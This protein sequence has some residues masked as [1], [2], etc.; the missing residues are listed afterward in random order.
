MSHLLEIRNL[1][2]E[3]PAD[4]DRQYAVEGLSLQ[5][6]RGETVCVV[7]E[8]GSGKSVTAHAVMQLLPEHALNISSGEI[9]LDGVNLLELDEDTMRQY[10]GSRLAMVFQEPMTALNPVMTVGDQVEETLLAH[11][12]LDGKVSRAKVIQLLAD[13][14]LPDPQ[15]LQHCYPFQLSG[16]QRQ[17]VVIAMAM[18]MQPGLLIADEPTTALD[19]TTQAQI[20]T[21]I[22]SLKRRLGIGVLFIT[23]DFGV[24][25]DIADRVAVMQNGRLVEFG[26]R[27]EVLHNPQH[28]YTRKLIAAVP[29]L[30][31]QNGLELTAAQRQSE[32]LLRINRLTKTYKARRTGMFSKAARIKALDEISLDIAEGETVGLLG[33]SGSGKTTLGQCVVRLLE[34]DSGSIDFSGQSIEKLRGP[35]LHRLRPQ[36]Q[37]IFQ[38]PYSSL[39]PR[40]KVGRII[41]ENAILHGVT[42]AEANRR[43]LEVLQLVGLDP[44]AVDRHPHEFSGGQRQ[45]IG[46]ARALVL[47]PRLIVADEPVSALDVSVQNQVL[48]LLLEI[49][50]KLGLSMLFITHDLRVASQVCDRIAVMHRGKIVECNTTEEIYR[51]PQHA[52]TRTLIDAMPGRQWTKNPQ[53]LPATEALSANSRRILRPDTGRGSSAS[54]AMA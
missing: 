25:A 5:L 15:S 12:Q 18:I 8:S 3:L 39:N 31:V 23:H 36:I 2:V 43:M 53:S 19:V 29:Q 26:T 37:M 35:A 28:P 13:M 45:R 40:H 21:L 54:L 17:R 41:T 52:Y 49:R 47:Q 51:S 33:E 1:T 20:L 9:I 11:G 27:D 30:R 48:A 24:V 10:R 14:H 6:D 50:R 7:G 42:R 22:D 38:D 44:S 4:S 32:P 34:A 16:G 46:I